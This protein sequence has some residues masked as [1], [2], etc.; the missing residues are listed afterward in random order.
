MRGTLA[1]FARK[2]ARGFPEGR[3]YMPRTYRVD[4]NTGR[5]VIEPLRL[6]PG[7]RLVLKSMKRR[8]QRQRRPHLYG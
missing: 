6:Q 3:Q 7:A 5:V 4:P 1:K 2:L 8:Y